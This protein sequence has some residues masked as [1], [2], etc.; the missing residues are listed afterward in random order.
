MTPEEK[1]KSLEILYKKFYDSVIDGFGMQCYARGMTYYARLGYEQSNGEV[2]TVS[3]ALP[4][5]EKM[6]Q[7]KFGLEF[8]KIM[9]KLATGFGGC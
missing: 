6:F 7:K 9:K 3:E 1:I 4:G 2:F 8:S 5:H